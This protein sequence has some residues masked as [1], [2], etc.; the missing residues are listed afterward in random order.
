MTCRRSCEADAGHGL[1]GGGGK[2]GRV[3][4]TVAKAAPGQPA[5]KAKPPTAACKLKPGAATPQNNKP[6]CFVAGTRVWTTAGWLA[7]EDV[8]WNA[9]VVTWLDEESG[10]AGSRATP[11]A[12]AAP[13]ERV[14]RLR[15]E[16]G[17]GDWSEAD[18]VRPVAWLGA[19]T[20]F[21]ARIAEA[22]DQLERIRREFA[23]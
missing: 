18:L 12:A 19:L 5:A 1:A 23:L 9:W 4:K 11:D 22:I 20:P 15:Q 13:S 17:D 21:G 10:D 16:R 6:K 3:A 14:V 8:R 7:I 2:K